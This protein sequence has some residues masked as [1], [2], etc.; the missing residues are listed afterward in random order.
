MKA[1]KIIIVVLGVLIAM[2]LAADIFVFVQGRKSVAHINV[3]EKKPVEDVDGE[4]FKVEDTMNRFMVPQDSGEITT[5]PDYRPSDDK[6]G[7]TTEESTQEEASQEDSQEEASQ[8]EAPQE[9]MPQEEPAE[10]TSDGA[11]SEYIFQDSDSRRLKKSD[12]K[13]MSKKDLK[14]ARNE[15]YARHGY[16]FKDK[17][18]AEYFEGKSW[19]TGTIKSE[20]FKDTER[21]NDIEIANRNLILEYEKKGR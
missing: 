10:E 7:G 17:S 11:D 9:E 14:L 6:E 13:G 12:L 19:Y 8:E 20:D 16:I 5:N 2:F 18:L 3:E 1:K 15:L 4:S 21:F